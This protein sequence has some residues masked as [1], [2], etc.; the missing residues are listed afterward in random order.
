MQ[1]YCLTFKN[2]NANQKIVVQAAN[3]EEAHTL[4]STML[5][6]HGWGDWKYTNNIEPI[7]G[8][9]APGADATVLRFKEAATA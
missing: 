9:I 1:I 8:F 4:A 6:E 3:P 7:R 5:E 2:G